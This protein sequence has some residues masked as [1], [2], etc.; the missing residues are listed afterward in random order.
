[1]ENREGVANESYAPGASGVRGPCGVF[2]P[3][4]GARQP[5]R[6]T[7]STRKPLSLNDLRRCESPARPAARPGGG[8]QPGN[9]G[10]TRM[11]RQ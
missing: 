7:A 3:C 10:Q 9:V 5:Q 6:L 4:T 8:I 11:K 2:D 1:M